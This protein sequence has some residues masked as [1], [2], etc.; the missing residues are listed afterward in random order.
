MPALGATQ[1]GP[2]RL[3]EVMSRIQTTRLEILYQEIEKRGVSFV[4]TDGVESQLLKQVN[5]FRPEDQ[6]GYRKLLDVIRQKEPKELVVAVTRFQ[7]GNENNV[8]DLRS[9]IEERLKTLKAPSDLL[10]IEPISVAAAP[11]NDEEA[12]KVGDEFGVHLVIWGDWR[13]KPDGGTTFHPRIRVVHESI[14]NPI[15]KG[16]TERSYKLD[17]AGS[18]GLDVVESGA[19][20]TSNLITLLVA[21]SYYNKAD[22]EHASQLFSTVP[23]ADSE[24]FFYLGNCSYRL[25]RND[26]AKT[27]FKRAIEL[28]NASL[29]AVHNLGVVQYE[30]HDFQEATR[31]FKRALSIDPSS[32]KTLNN[33]GIVAAEQGDIEAGIAY[34]VK[35]TSINP[36]SDAAWYNLGAVLADTGTQ[37]T[38]KAVEAFKRHL[39]VHS[40]DVDTWLFCGDLLVRVLTSAEPARSAEYRQEASKLLLTA[41]AKNAGNEKLLQAYLN[42]FPLEFTQEEFERD[43]NYI[44][45]LAKAVSSP[46]SLKNTIRNKLIGRTILI[47]VHLGNLEKAR[48]AVADVVIDPHSMTTCAHHLTYQLALGAFVKLDSSVFAKRF[49]ATT[50]EYFVRLHFEGS[51]GEET[52]TWYDEYNALLKIRP[53]D[54]GTLIA[55]ATLQTQILLF[56]DRAWMRYGFMK[57][58]TDVNEWVGN[59]IANARNSLERV[60]ARTRDPQIKRWLQE[61]EKELEHVWP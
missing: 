55:K 37:N 57:G 59:F 50:Y 21:L 11:I 60:S 18:S 5:A 23:E 29:K 7:G 43:Q 19:L 39:E 12:Y 8:A 32:D 6:N 27:Y 3:E 36:R 20:K 16:A 42:F 49:Y 46:S 10:R 26:R 13:S 34:L 22:Y 15:E 14:G 48:A 44:A 47:H 38:R 54:Q 33:L 25:G 28:D 61:C 53:L 41:I 56:H 1:G 4:L 31:S 51:L 17:L 30:E 9:A 2:L 35:A 40:E 52:K 24:V 58:G 45:S